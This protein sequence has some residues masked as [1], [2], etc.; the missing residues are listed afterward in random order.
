MKLIKNFKIK[1]KLFVLVSTA[2]IFLI[3]ISAIGYIYM[4]QM[5][6]NT[7]EMY[8][9]RLIPIKNINLIRN[10]N[11][12]LDSF[13]LELM[14]TND[15][16]KQVD[17]E[18]K[19][20]ERFDQNNQLMNEY[21]AT[22]LDAASKQNFNHLQEHLHAY[23]K[24]LQTIV[25]LA[26]AGKSDEAYSLYST[27]LNSVKVA[28]SGYSDVISDSNIKA[29]ENLNKAN[30][31]KKNQATMIMLFVSLLAAVFFTGMG[32]V[33]IKLITSPMKEIQSL[34][35]KA[36]KGDFTIRGS[37]QSKDELGLLSESFNSMVN[38]IQGLIQQ[39]TQTSEHV[40]SAAEQLTASTEMTNK[41][42]EHIASTI[43]ELAAGTD[44]QVQ[45]VGGT[46]KVINEMSASVRHIAQN[47]HSAS[48][49]ALVTSEKALEGNETISNV[50]HQMNSINQTVSLLGDTIRGLGERSKEIGSI[51]KVITDISAQTNLLALNAA[52]EAAR[53]GEHGRGF[54][55]VAAEV[56]KLAE[57]SAGSAQKI[58]ALITSIQ[59]ETQSAIF[60]MEQAYEEVNEGIG[61]VNTAGESFEEIQSSVKEVATEI[62]D[63]SSAVQQMAASSEQILDAINIVNEVA[64]AAV[65]GTV[66]VS[67]ATE[68]QLASMEEIA[69]SSMALSK[70]AEELKSLIGEFKV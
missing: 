56:R 19:I 55:V 26:L 37:V 32:L 3:S 33:I 40:A 12:A 5:S 64:A 62:L 43:Q 23:E 28:V 53:A 7:K 67:S 20:N 25:D 35:A 24:E 66:E 48:D 63:V 41:A 27:K 60:S 51:I 44:Q 18:T 50:I 22:G 9:D 39:V 30:A 17:L 31:D 46:K 54:A 13:V 11:R 57:Q 15:R 16:A 2:I 14:I 29:S 47:A 69:A 38:G 58:A 42:T 6:A 61:I 52:I 8:T 59:S 34:M 4:S 70:V 45:S 36:E 21:E 10:N 49:K 68:E 1:N 65:T